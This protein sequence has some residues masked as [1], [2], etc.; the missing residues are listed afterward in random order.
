MGRYAN[1]NIFNLGLSNGE[2]EKKKEVAF[3]IER[4]SI[5]NII[6]N[7]KN[8]YSIDGIEELKFSI[9]HNGLKQN[10]EV[11]DNGNGTYSL[12]SGERRYTALK[13][14]ISEGHEQF[15]LVPCLI[16]DV[17][18]SSSFLDEN[19][20]EILTNDDKEMWS[21]ITTNSEGR[22]YTDADRAF[23][24]RELKRIY[25]KLANS[26]VR[27]P[28]KMSQLIAEQLDMSP[29]QVKR[30][31]FVETHGTD[32][33]KEKFNNNEISIRAAESVAHLSPAQQRE[34][35]QKEYVTSSTVKAHTEKKE[36][37]KS[38]RK[39]NAILKEN[40][41]ITLKN[42]DTFM[43]YI[44]EIKDKSNIL[45]TD[46]NLE[47]DKD[48]FEILMIRTKTLSRTIDEIMHLLNT[49]ISE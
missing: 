27:L 31:N 38:Q 49:N 21:I 16:T 23:Q 1:T 40:K 12:L 17:S 39:D 13:G 30:F 36:K 10:L 18:K 35:L 37:K 41:K 14:L 24:V 29:T 25:T 26:G 34:V 9:L 5:N 7:I 32:E 11:T 47:I 44:Q 19:G 42:S 48:D 4:I 46:W 2:T 8:E 15:T 22:Q 20:N 28:G 33:L 43:K 45:N 3:R 6:P